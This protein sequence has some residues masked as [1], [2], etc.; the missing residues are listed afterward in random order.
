MNKDGVNQILKDVYYM[1]G[2]TINY[3]KPDGTQGVLNKSYADVIMEASREAGISPYHLAS[4]IRQEQ[5]TG[6]SASATASGN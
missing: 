4:R 3:T 2:N 1:Q 6:N 5:G